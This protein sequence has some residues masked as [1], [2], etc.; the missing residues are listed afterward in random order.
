M[1]CQAFSI[2][3]SKSGLISA[4]FSQIWYGVVAHRQHKGVEIP[5]AQDSTDPTGT[6]S[7]DSVQWNILNAG[8]L[9][10]CHTPNGARR[11]SLL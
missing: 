4:L 9:V 1:W 10:L 11:V 3:S 6:N 2:R 8:P 5:V 7:F